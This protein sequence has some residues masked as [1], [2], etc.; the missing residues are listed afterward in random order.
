MVKITYLPYQE[1][2]VHEIIEQDNET[3]F[4]DVIRQSLTQTQVEPS[5]NWIDGVAFL[6]LAFQP[7][8]DIVRENLTGKIHFSSVIFTKIEYRAQHPVK[9]GSQAFSVRLRKAD[10]NRLLVGLIRFLKTFKPSPDS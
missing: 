5:V 9:L 6:V 8:E 1:L 3:F 10:N 4:E 7:T 2:V